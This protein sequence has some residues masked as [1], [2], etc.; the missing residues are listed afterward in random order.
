MHRKYSGYP[1]LSCIAWMFEIKVQGGHSFVKKK[2]NYM[3]I[4]GGRFS[5]LLRMKFI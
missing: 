4:Y 3:Y 2:K 5:A 1:F